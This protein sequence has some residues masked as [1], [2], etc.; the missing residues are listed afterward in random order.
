MAKPLYK[1]ADGHLFYGPS[2]ANP[3]LSQMHYGKNHPEAPGTWTPESAEVEYD[4]L[5]GENLVPLNA[6]AK[7]RAQ[8]A[9]RAEKPLPPLT[10]EEREELQTMRDRRE[11]ETLRELD[12]LRAM[13]S[14]PAKA[15]SRGF[16]DAARK[17][18]AAEEALKALTSGAV[19]DIARSKGA[20]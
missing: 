13:K 12:R 9:A 8:E 3:A 14:E 6:E 18:V 19:A 16:A 17:R 5:P 11:L 4:G 7:K 15:A 20:P 1:V 10:A 2:R